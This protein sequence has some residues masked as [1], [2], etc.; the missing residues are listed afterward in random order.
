MDPSSSPECR[1]CDLMQVSLREYFE[2]R[3]AASE[4]A[5]VLARDLMNSRLEGMNE[6]RKQIDRQEATYAT[7][8]MLEETVKRI[9]TDLRVLRE[10][11]AELAGKAS[12]SS[13]IMALVLAVSG[14]V[15]S[16]L[17]LAWGMVK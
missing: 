13:V 17:G 5:L 11:R 7:R 14:L 3:L 1:R 12:A 9:E 4:Q 8:L 15:L 16:A 10:S 2:S 6:L